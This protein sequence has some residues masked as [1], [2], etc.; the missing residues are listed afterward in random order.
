MKGTRSFLDK[1][2][3]A[4]CGSIRSGSRFGCD[5]FRSMPRWPLALAFAAILWTSGPALTAAAAAEGEL[6]EGAVAAASEGTGETAT[7]EP[8][9]SFFSSTTVT[10]TGSERDVFQVATPV[11]VVTAKEL[12][13]LAPANAADLLREQPG[14]DVNGV[15]P[16]QPRP[17]IRG[18]RGLRVLFL[19]DG[20]RLNN[21]RRQSDFGEI[22]GLID[23]DSVGS[24][25]VV[26]GPA[27][28]L[29]GSD[30]IGGVL[31]V[32]TAPPRLGEGR[33]FTAGLEG[34]YGSAAESKRWS[35]QA[36]GVLGRFDY[37]I[38]ASRR[39]SEQ[40]E[41][42]AGNFG[43]IR[44][45]ESTPVQD[46]GLQDDGVWGSA[47][48]DIND[49]HSL[50][51]RFNRYRADETGFGFVEPELLGTEEAFRIRITYPYQKFDRWSL[52][53][54]GSALESILADSVEFKVY[55]QNNRRQLAN[56]I[57]INIG[58]IFPGAPNSGV[59]ADT[60]NFTDLDTSGLR[61]EAIKAIGDKHLLTWGSEAFQDD[62]FNTDASVTTTTIRLPFPPF[63][64]VSTTRDTVANA[65]NA[66][67]SSW[68]VFL[69]EEWTP[70]ARLRVSGGLR[71]QQTQTRAER[72][73][74][75][76]IAGLD[77]DDDALVGSLTASWQLMPELNLV[78]SY[79][80]AF[81]APSI[82]ERLFNGVTP[83][84]DGFQV[85]NAALESESSDN[86]EVGLKYRR[87]NAFL[88]GVVFRTEIDEGIV[89][90]FLSPAEIA[91]L[92]A[93]QRA[94][95]SAARVRFVVQ[96]RNVQRL[97]YQGVELAM[98]YR[99]A[100]DITVGGNYTHLDSDLLDSQ[101][102]PTGDT[103]GDKF[104][105]F[106]RWE[107][108]ERPFWCEYRVRHNA[109]EAVN[110]AVGAPVPAVGRTLPS[111]TV[112]T[113]AAGVSLFAQVRFTHDVRLAVENLTN[114]LYAE[115]SNATF[116]R[117]EPGRN[118]TASYRVR[119]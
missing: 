48:W 12:E 109:S 87:R 86:F 7:T 40:Y 19:A 23:L 46:T 25:E 72:T 50:R 101:N 15:G 53:Y 81:R 33:R 2:G 65:P 104:V 111:F 90:H 75:W 5:S 11:T 9:A 39:D 24:V 103:Y 27:S 32:V 78:T 105:A 6:V 49:R 99:T 84:G 96:Q 41:A 29:Y 108:A 82:I 117:P 8:V 10:A 91:A 119:F 69:Q 66:Q 71:Y 58:P 76:N 95:I 68:G 21:A 17:V 79:G 112:H 89:Q 4:L 45:R 56:D 70:T 73:P 113:V 42:P 115:F 13:R 57:E 60:L 64:R 80:S 43:A 14:V 55:T 97:R 3:S 22:S 88:E 51:L 94:E 59:H 30:A 54:F 36:A 74:N 85:L 34:R 47:G 98:G 102:P 67:N 114:E 37:Q 52:S 106:V 118:V 116:F 107:P 77:F 1:L 110:L 35:A 63:Q 18:Q 16:N 100:T 28:V 31:N 62:S 38:G 93:A 20:L 92:P 83:E 44:L 61:L 26:R